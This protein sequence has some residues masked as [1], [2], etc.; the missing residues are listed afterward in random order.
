MWQ[1]L[2]NSYRSEAGEIQ[3]SLS[4]PGDS[5]WFEGH[6]PQDP[7]LPALA[8]LAMVRDLI[9]AV[10]ETPGPVT[11]FSRVKFKKM[12][13]PGDRL[14]IFAAAKAGRADAYAFRIEAGRD[15][16]CSGSITFGKVAGPKIE[17]IGP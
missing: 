8:Q 10:V 17:S 13:R 4:I 5:P 14:K 12:I 1:L 16:V 2:G 3:T 6:F 15:V 9:R 7:V 11:G